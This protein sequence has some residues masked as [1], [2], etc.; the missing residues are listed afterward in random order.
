MN[1]HKLI[2]MKGITCA[3]KSTIV[4][5][6]KVDEN[7]IVLSSDSLRQSLGLNNTDPSV[8]GVI[9]KMAHDFLNRGTSVII[10][11]TNLTHKRHNQ[12]REIAQNKGV[13]YEC[14]YI[15]THPYLWEKNAQERIQTLWTD[16]TMEKM[17]NIRQVMF[18][19]L[20]FPLD[21][22]FD[23][24]I[25]HVSDIEVDPF[26]INFFKHYYNE[27][28]DLFLENPEEFFKPMIQCGFMDDVMPEFMA[29]YGFDQQ[30]PNHNLTL[31]KHTYKLCENLKDKSEVMV[32]AGLLHDLGKVVKGIQSRK[33]NGDCAYIGHQGA[34]TEIAFCI[35][36]RL[37]FPI[38]FIRE[39]CILVNKHMFLPYEGTLRPQTIEFLG[40]E[41]YQDLL[42][43]RQADLLAKE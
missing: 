32:W 37:G 14:H 30:N 9:N 8:F 22:E 33:E 13:A 17:F 39:V 16:Y 11:A 41:L 34:S 10:D 36:N 40:Q 29:T 1:N 3:G 31:E 27:H 15:I 20:A 4:E 25:F 21:K 26:S 35:L 18:R 6:L 12:Y 42:D 43:F 5:Q 28:K 7:A 2:L 23:N 19:G 24:V 38:D